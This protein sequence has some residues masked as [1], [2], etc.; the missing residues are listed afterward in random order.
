MT[1]YAVFDTNVI[2]SSLLTHNLDSATVMVVDAIADGNIVPLYNDDVLD[3][4]ISVLRRSKFK[5]SKRV[6]DDFIEMIRH[7]GLNVDPSPT[8]MTLIDM[9]DLV[10]FEI[11]MQKRDDNAYLVTG[12][13]KHFPERD[14]IVTPA[15]MVQIMSLN[16]GV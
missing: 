6:I 5:I 11:V 13:L 14:F 7:T 1:Y 3:E 15:E 10:F 8:G 4:Y 9:D 2:V 12:N 16:K